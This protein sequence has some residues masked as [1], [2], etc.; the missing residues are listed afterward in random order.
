MFTTLETNTKKIT[1]TF[2]STNYSINFKNL[3]TEQKS[4]LS[5]ACCGTIDTWVALPLSN[6]VIYHSHQTL[7]TAVRGKNL[8]VY[9]GYFG[10]VVRGL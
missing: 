7:K 9:E 1:L 3:L 8:D 2:L 6:L 10:K 5:G 4:I